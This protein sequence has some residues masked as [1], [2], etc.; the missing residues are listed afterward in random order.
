MSQGKPHVG[1][2]RAQRSDDRAGQ[3]GH[4]GP[5]SEGQG[6]DTS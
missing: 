4:A 3:R 6:V 2:D 5:T 1:V